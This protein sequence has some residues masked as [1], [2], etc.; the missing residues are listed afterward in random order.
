LR[1]AAPLEAEIQAAFFEWWELWATSHRIPARLCFAVPNGGHR[2]AA[3][4]G[5]LKAQGVRAG[6]PDVFLMIPAGGFHALIL[7]FKREGEKVRRGSEQEAFIDEARLRSY[8]VLV[9]HST[10]QAMKIV[11]AYLS[12]ADR[13]EDRVPMRV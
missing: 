3:V 11:M 4:A 8:N 12:D 13:P 9:V 7:E 5:K 6:V 2:H 10:E 1:S